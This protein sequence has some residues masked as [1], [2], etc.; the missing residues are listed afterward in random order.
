L[1]IAV[2]E[3]RPDEICPFNIGQIILRPMMGYTRAQ[4]ICLQGDEQNKRIVTAIR[5]RDENNELYDVTRVFIDELERHPFAQHDDFIDASSRIYDLEPVKPEA[6]Y[7]GAGPM[8]ED[9]APGS[10]YHGEYDA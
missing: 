9:R 10:S 7:A 1:I 5:R 3:G 8:L 6:V 2:A 4:Q